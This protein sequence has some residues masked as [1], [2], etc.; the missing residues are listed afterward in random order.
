MMVE[1]TWMIAAK[2]LSQYNAQPPSQISK[3]Y[4][5]FAALLVL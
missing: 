2:H 3:T 5:E 1:P 4:V